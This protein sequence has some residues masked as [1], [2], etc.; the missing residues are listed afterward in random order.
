MSDQKSEVE[1]LRIDRSALKNRGR[2]PSKIGPIIG[3]AVLIGVGWLFKRPILQYVDQMRLPQVK[4]VRVI[5]R[6]ASAASGA[7]G[8]SAN[9]YVIARTRAAL[10]SDA[11]GRLVEL[12]VVEGSFVKKGEVVARLYY[13]EYQAQHNQAEANLAQS[14]AGVKRADSERARAQSALVALSAAERAAEAQLEE[15]G[16]EL[17]LAQSDHDR[18][19]KLVEAGVESSRKLDEAVRTLGKCQARENSASARSDQAKAD[20]TQG[21]A[22]IT[23]AAAA[24][25]EAQ[26]QIAIAEAA[27]D[28][29]QATL[30]KTYV[31]APFDGVVTNKE[32][33]VGEVV[34]PNSQGGSRARGSV[35]TM[36]DLDTLEVQSDVPETTLS[37]IRV[38]GDALVYLDAF[39]NDP[40]AARVDRVWPTADRQKATVEVRVAFE[41][42]DDRLRPEMGVRIVFLRDDS[43]LDAEATPSAPATLVSNDAVVR[44]GGKEVVFVLEGGRAHLR[45]E[46]Q[47]G[48]SVGNNRR[49][50]AGLEAGENVILSPDPELADGD[51]V[52]QV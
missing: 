19:G 35:V 38:G 27:R 32:A 24:L 39:P 29:A 44:R 50:L 2:G 9:G 8:V 14:L 40:Y 15:A 46:L 18:M 17:V 30:A 25:A 47:L 33:E 41:K 4:T 31:R 5:E 52:I 7:A 11:P 10:S 16:V 3:V 13:D 43:S 49:V 37:S 51:R 26:S 42:R 34:S 12:N 23:V 28:L 48:E 36:V 21:E 1:A 20:Y 22:Q 45:T 6:S